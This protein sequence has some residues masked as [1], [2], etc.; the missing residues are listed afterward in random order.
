MIIVPMGCA[1]ELNRGCR[2]D[3]N[4]F[5]KK[6]V[7]RVDQHNYR[8]MNQQRSNRRL[9]YGAEWILRIPD[10]RRLR[11]FHPWLDSVPEASAPDCPDPKKRISLAAS[12]PA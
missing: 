10:R 11:R 9:Q 6:P 8:G 1:D 7:L 4:M 12:A 2:V 5:K 3:S